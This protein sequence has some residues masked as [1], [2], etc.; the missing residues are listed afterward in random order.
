MEVARR[1]KE[2]AELKM[3]AVRKWTLALEQKIDKMWSPCASLAI[4]LEEMTPRGLAAL[5]RMVENLD[6]YFGETK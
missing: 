2:E 3:Q 5:D 1:R 6:A 4:L